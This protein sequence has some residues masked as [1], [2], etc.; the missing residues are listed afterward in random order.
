MRVALFH[1]RFDAPRGAEKVCLVHAHALRALGW[2]VKLLCFDW[3]GAQFSP[4]D[5]ALDPRLLPAPRR[6]WSGRPDPATLAALAAE[7]EDRDVAV[8]H[9]YPA[10]AYL[11][12]APAAVPRRWYCE[13]PFRALYVPETRP[14][15]HRAYLDGRLDRGSQVGRYYRR[16]LRQSAWNL[17]LNPRYRGKRAADRAGVARLD[18]VAANS[19]ATAEV[20][21]TIYGR[22]AEVLYCPVDFPP[23]LPPPAADG[24]PLRILTMGGFSPLKGLTLLLAG[25]ERFLERTRAP[26][27]LEIVGAGR[28]RA[29]VERAIAGSRTAACAR[30]HGWISPSELAA[31]RAQCHAFAAMPA[32]EPFGLV[33]GEALAQGLIAVGPDHGGPVEIL[34]GGEYGFV[35]DPFVPASIAGALERLLALGSAERQALRERAFAAARARFDAAELPARLERWLR[36]PPAR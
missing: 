35:A 4:A 22:A 15:L 31:L 24:G 13:E 12:H 9:N 25:F 30:I 3:Q 21:A 27:A 16:A 8:A 1:P 28:E 5:H 17:A 14:G 23:A 32:D 19:A 29:D 18:G 20:F 34:G 6:L 33:F 7:L 36:P 11:G 10:S 26:V 2:D